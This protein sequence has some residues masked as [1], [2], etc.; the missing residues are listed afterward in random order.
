MKIRNTV[1]AVKEIIGEKLEQEFSTHLACSKCGHHYIRNG[2]Y[3]PNCGEEYRSIIV[4]GHR[5]ESFAIAD[6]LIKKG[7]DA[8][9]IYSIKDEYVIV[10]PNN[11]DLMLYLR[12]P[13]YH[14][15]D[16][17]K[18]LGIYKVVAEKH[19][20]LD[21]HYAVKITIKRNNTG[22]EI[23]N[24]LDNLPDSETKQKKEKEDADRKLGRKRE[25]IIGYSNVASDENEE[26]TGEKQTASVKEDEMSFSDILNDCFKDI[27]A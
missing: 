22:D 7:Y 25:V 2:A 6:G 23:N 16:K 17:I 5:Y 1:A 26:D 11:S 3:C 8:I 20:E 19:N 9:A 24:F 15:D 21:H 12:T 4:R 14:A 10:V 13:W 27:S 18:A